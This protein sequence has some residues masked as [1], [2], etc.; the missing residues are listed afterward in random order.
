MGQGLFYSGRFSQRPGFSLDCRE[1]GRAFHYPVTM[2]RMACEQLLVVSHSSATVVCGACVRHHPSTLEQAGAG[3]AVARLQADTD[4]VNEAETVRCAGSLD[5]HGRPE[6]RRQN[7]RR[8]SGSRAGVGRIQRPGLAA[9][10][11]PANALPKKLAVP[12]NRVTM[13]LNGQRS[14]ASHQPTA[15]PQRATRPRR[16]RTWMARSPLRLIFLVGVTGLLA[17]SC[18]PRSRRVDRG[19]LSTS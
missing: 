15:V 1:S 14:V 2:T 6:R 19:C 16:K 3:L 10:S 11:S 18:S 7:P 4:R 8:H 12:V 5:N 13:I 17:W 9:A